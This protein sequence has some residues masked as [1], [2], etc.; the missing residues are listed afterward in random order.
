MVA[1]VP[2]VRVNGFLR[3]VEQIRQ[4]ADVRLDPD[5]RA[6]LG[7]FFSPGSTA[8]LVASMVCLDEL[9][10]QMRLL[11]PGAGVGSLTAALAARI[12][13]APNPPLSVS[14][15]ACELDS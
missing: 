13:E 4:A 2:G 6:E 7:Q 15:T 3:W 1:T 5:R 12:C 10:D 14:V 8:R 11:D 9:P